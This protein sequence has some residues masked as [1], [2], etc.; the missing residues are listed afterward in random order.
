M[1]QLI[2]LVITMVVAL[3]VDRTS[4]ERTAEMPQHL[5]QAINLQQAILEA[6]KKL[7]FLIGPLW[8]FTCP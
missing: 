5:N 1:D 4:A 6:Q 3:D 2:A 8:W 7:V